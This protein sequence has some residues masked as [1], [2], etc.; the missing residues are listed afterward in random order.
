MILPQVKSESESEVAESCPSLPGSS[1]RGIFQ[2]RVLEWV[3][4]SFSRDLPDPGIELRS[5][6]LQT[7][8]L[9]SELWGEPKEIILNLIKIKSTKN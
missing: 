4:L 8:T 3:A 2:A 5:P 9:P 7:D 6:T 1:V